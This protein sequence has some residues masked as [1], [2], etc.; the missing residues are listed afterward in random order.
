MSIKDEL[1]E[2]YKDNKD[3]VNKNIK[4]TKS[5]INEGV[6][7]KKSSIS[8]N[9]EEKK[10]A[11]SESI[12]EKKDS[13]S[14][15]IAETKQNVSETVS[16]GVKKTKSFLRKVL[17]FGLIA[18]II[19]GGL[20]ML[21]CSYTFSEGTRTGTLTKISKKGMILK[22]YEGQLNVGGVSTGDDGLVGNIWEFSVKDDRIYK[23]LQELEG[24]HVTLHYDQVI[25][26]MPWQGDTEYFIEMVEEVKKD[27]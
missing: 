10:E 24:K 8:E 5:T 16:S 25:K 6:E 3:A 19:G 7:E 12:Q 26:A 18:A 1:N 14:E 9:L 13:I 20:Y 23:Q 22:T 15:S 17:M 2:D 4:E 27:D 21:Y 11:I